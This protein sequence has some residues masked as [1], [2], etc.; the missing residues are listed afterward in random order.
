MKDSIRKKLQSDNNKIET[1]GNQIRQKENITKENNSELNKAQSSLQIFKNIRD[2]SS[3]WEEMSVP[4]GYDSA[5]ENAPNFYKT[6]DIKILNVPER[7]IPFHVEILYRNS[8]LEDNTIL[9]F[10]YKSI[11]YELEDIDG[12][13]NKNVT[14][15]AGLYIFETRSTYP[16]NPPLDAKLSIKVINPSQFI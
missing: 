4:T 8:T 9:Y 16:I 13:N 10:P 7:F 3:E 15:H 2:F 6:W 1:L 11:F 5:L 14:I 12:S